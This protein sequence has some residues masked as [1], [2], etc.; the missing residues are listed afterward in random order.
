MLTNIQIQ[1]YFFDCHVEKN[2]IY[3]LSF[4]VC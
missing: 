2:I 1:I 3:N 4:I